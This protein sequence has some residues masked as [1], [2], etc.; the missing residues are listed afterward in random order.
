MTIGLGLR[1]R[2]TDLDIKGDFAGLQKVQK[3]WGHCECPHPPIAPQNLLDL[4]GLE[5]GFHADHDF[6]PSQPTL[7]GR[8]NERLERVRVARFLGRRFRGLRI[9]LFVLRPLPSDFHRDLALLQLLQDLLIV[10]DLFVAR[11]LRLR[12]LVVDA[13][14][15]HHGD[16]NGVAVELLLVNEFDEFD[17]LAF[18]FGDVLVV[19]LEQRDEFFVRLRVFFRDGFDLGLGTRL[20]GWGI[21]IFILVLFDGSGG[22]AAGTFAKGGRGR[23]GGLGSGSCRFLFNGHNGGTYLWFWW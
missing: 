6:P 21:F 12:R 1:L 3:G 19:A 8:R 23:R 11:V 17:E 18:R 16:D 15:D 22:T 7:L 14:G 2:D 20:C 4:G 13:A 10:E 5:F 9:L